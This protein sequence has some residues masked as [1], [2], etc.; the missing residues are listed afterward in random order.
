MVPVRTDER[1]PV[2]IHTVVAYLLARVPATVLQGK[3]AK[4][5]RAFYE[6]AERHPCLLAGLAFSQHSSNP[7]SKVLERILFRLA[8]AGLISNLNP[9]FKEMTMRDDAK[10]EIRD[11]YGATLERLR[12]EVD[13]A[14]EEL[15][16]KLSVDAT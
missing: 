8:G 11:A 7:H 16:A 1:S 9:T 14:A 15:A 13:S 2:D 6:V 5:H 10:Q 3:Q 12:G 4:V